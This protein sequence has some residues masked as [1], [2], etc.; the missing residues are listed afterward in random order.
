MIRKNKFAL[1][2]GA[3]SGLGKAL[4]LAMAQH[5]IYIFA[6]GNCE[7]HLQDIKDAYPDLIEVF[8]YDISKSK[9]WREIASQLHGFNLNYV[10]H[11]ATSTE[12]TQTIE[13]MNYDSWMS[14]M[15]INLNAPVFLTKALVSNS[16]TLQSRVLFVS[17]IGAQVPISGSGSHCISKAALEM[18]RKV[19]SVESKPYLLASFV[20][21]TM[22]IMIHSRINAS[23]KYMQSDVG[24]SSSKQKE[25]SY[26]LKTYAERIYCLLSN[27]T[28]EVFTDDIWSFED[29]EKF[30]M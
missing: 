28:D 21:S 7:T 22:D 26:Q 10:I 12:P 19:L 11:A 8:N 14:T 24:Y 5:G 13:Q 29:I 9:S 15:M 30:Y 16:L 17:S 23:V 1:I 4:T 3:S 20:P 6:L 2:T 18:A 25:E 27:T